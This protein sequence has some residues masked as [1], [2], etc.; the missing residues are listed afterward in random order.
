MY[1]LCV[2]LWLMWSAIAARLPGR[3]DNEI[4][5]YWNTHIKKRLLRSGID[6]VTHAPRLDLLD[7]TSILRT[8]LGNPSLLDLQ[9]LVGAQAL[10]NPELLKLAATAS[11]FA[12]QNNTQQQQQ[13]H[14]NNVNFQAQSREFNQFQTPNQINNVDG[15]IGNMGNLRCSSS[16]QNT[17]PTYLGENFVLQQNQVDDLIGKDQTLVQCLSNANEKLGY[18]SVISSPNHLNNNSSSTY[19]NSSTGEEERDSYCSDLF[20]FEIPDNLDISDFL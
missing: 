14:Y 2:A 17:I 20:N 18:D 8:V 15:F 13:L 5:N 11:L 12:S 10:I 16:L 7:M 9:A 1:V 3:T 19:V 6:P 4:K